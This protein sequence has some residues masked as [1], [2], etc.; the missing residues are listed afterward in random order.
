MD[1]QV[2]ETFAEGK[3]EILG[4]TALTSGTTLDLKGI[5]FQQTLAV[6]LS[7]TG[8]EM[9]RLQLLVIAH[10]TEAGPYAQC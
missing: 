3:A 9:T 1:L 10:K 6:G 4:V 2:Q 5:G 8:S 7:R